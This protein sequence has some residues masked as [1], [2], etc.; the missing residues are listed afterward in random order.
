VRPSSQTRTRHSDVASYLA[1]VSA[2]PLLGAPVHPVVMYARLLPILADADVPEGRLTEELR[3]L[4]QD[5]NAAGMRDDL[6]G[7]ALHPGAMLLKR[8]CKHRSD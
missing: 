1:A 7:R 3:P 2:L 5:A 4:H 6:A 8:Q